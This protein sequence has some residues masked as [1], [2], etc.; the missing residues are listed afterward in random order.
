MLRSTIVSLAFAIAAVCPGSVAAGEHA[1][2]GAKAETPTL[3]TPNSSP[4]YNGLNHQPT[5]N[6]LDALQMR[7]VT[8]EQ[9]RKVDRLYDQLMASS[10]NILA[11][12][13]GSR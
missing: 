6:Q 1:G 3:E 7:D 13:P 2:P 11:R 4:I 12:R 9:A 5:Q 10:Q 8:P